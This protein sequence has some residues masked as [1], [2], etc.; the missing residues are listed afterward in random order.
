MI[1]TDLNSKPPVVGVND[2]PKSLALYSLS[3]RFQYISYV[4]RMLVPCNPEH[5]PDRFPPQC[6]NDL[7]YSSVDTAGNSPLHRNQP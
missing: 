5:S 6:D 7:P 3:D 2:A 4:H 1:F